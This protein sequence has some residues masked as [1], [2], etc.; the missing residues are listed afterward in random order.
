MFLLTNIFNAQSNQITVSDTFAINLHNK[1]KISSLNIIPYSEIIYL[2]GN[3][4]VNQE[5][6]II[7]QTGVFSL[8]DSLDYKLN[9]TIIIFYNTVQLGLKSEYKKRNLVVSYEDQYS[10]SIRIVRTEIQ[11]FSSEAIFG[12]DIQRSGAIIR[13]FSIGTNRD[14]QLNSGLRLQLSGKLSDDIEI[15]AALTD[16]NTPIQPEGNTE[17]LDEIDKVFIELRHKNV[18]GT[19]GDYELNER[20]N[21]FS[22]ITR[23]LQGLKGEFNFDN[24]R[25]V[26]AIAGSRGKFNSNAYG[27]SD[28]NQGP[29]RLL[30]ANNERAIIV[31]AGSEKVFLDGE[32]LT[33][34]ENN[35][36]VIDYSNSQI[37]FTPKRLIT[38]ASRINIDFEYTDQNYKRNFFGTNLSSK[39]LNNKLDVGI[40]YY[41]EGDDENSPIELSFSEED[42]NIMRN[43]AGERNNAVKSGISLSL[44][45][46]LG[47]QT[48]LYSRRDT[49]I[50][51]QLVAYYVYNPGSQEAIYNISFS[52]VGNGKGDYIR[53]SLGRYRFVGINNGS[54]LP[55]IYLPLPELKQIGNLSIKAEV[56]E[57]VVLDFEISGSMW[58]KNRFSNSN[59]SQV[60]GYARK[61]NINIIPQEISIGGVSLGKAGISFKDRFIDKRYSTLDRINS[62]EFN[63]EYNIPTETGNDQSLR[64][65]RVHL[66]PVKQLYVMSQ[67]GYMK[68]GNIFNSERILT[69]LKLLDENKYQL[70]YSI[71]FVKSENSIVNTKWN[72]QNAKSFY[73]LGFLKPGFDFL[74]ENK[75]D[76]QYD[77]LLATS[78]RYLEVIP[79]LELSPSNSFNVKLS[80]SIREESFPINKQLLKQSEAST[81]QLQINYSGLREVNSSLSLIL[82]NKRFTDDFKNIGFGD[83]ETILFLSQNRFN[84]WQGFIQG[85]LFYQAAT[86]QTAR[87]E[88]VFVKVP[89]GTGS[90]IYLGDLNNN[91]IPEE[92][93]FQLTSYDGEYII[94]TIPTEELFP[95]IDL[96]T[97]TRWKLSFERII[98]GNGFWHN[99]IKA[100][101]TETFF[102]IEEYSKENQTRDIY[103]LKFSK[104]LND[105]T[106]VRGSQLFQQDFNLFQN[107]N[108][109]SLRLRFIQ[110]RNLNQF[111]AGLERGF[112]K[113]RAIRLRA[114]LVPEVNTQTEFI[115]LI[116]NLNSP[117]NSGRA[118]IVTRNDISTE[119]SYRPIRNIESGLKI[120]AGRSHDNLPATPIQVDINSVTLRI[121]YSITNIGRIRAEIERVELISNSSNANIPFEITRGN[122]IG[123]N[124]FWRLFFDYRIANYIQTSFSYDARLHGKSK[125]IHS[126]RAEA[127]AYF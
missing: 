65:L 96:K 57:G 80:Y 121:N 89:K 83:N 82:R 28:G 111:S 19:F 77:S 99:A 23:K 94:V 116:D 4:L 25:G 127:R 44:P 123:K 3:K 22:Q 1:Y 78:L 91:G 30:G 54:Y 112:Y 41:R 102:R 36:Y 45:D 114:Q 74:F 20:N 125:I 46:S 14:F 79:S 122:V 86:E 13:G 33:R 43:A 29:Y 42:L 117:P 115:N 52:F 110:R 16:E 93:E 105:S 60:N 103:L 67:Y 12:R 17:T 59:E 11:P 106:T 34:G 58:E 5:Y 72:R 21:E 107:S 35:D 100:L 32:L 119:F 68:Q 24:Y 40:S 47:R 2:S 10:D 39:I 75:E 31:I 70:D 71:D 38:S 26:I 64:E 95:V 97:N 27:G 124:Y 109:F 9:D 92:N 37:T 53:E 8:F 113:E 76:R 66:F 101:S 88:K 126:L 63:R 118:R 48:G 18:V 84:L 51:Q 61:L 6:K 15:V 87:L 73:N 55:I 81:K 85:D 90:Y 98:S 120:H 62:V 108:S 7:Y 49:T 69:E 50:N 104:L 56:L